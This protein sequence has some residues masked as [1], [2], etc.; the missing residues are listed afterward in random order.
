M[1]YVLNYRHDLLVCFAPGDS[2]CAFAPQ[3]ARDLQRR[4]AELV[5]QDVAVTWTPTGDADE[6]VV[7]RV[8]GT[9]LMVVVSS[10]GFASV[11]GLHQRELWAFL[12]I[13]VGTDARSEPGSRLLMVEEVHRTPTSPDFW[14]SSSRDCR[15]MR[16]GRG[17]WPGP[18]RRRIR[19]I[20]VN[21]AGCRRT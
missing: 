12:E 6:S 13:L 1:S 8:T 2:A 17:R 5:S 11:T 20:G 21:Y 19:C 4:L 3:L 7:E 16:S 14:N 9:V 15:A 10:R 18:A